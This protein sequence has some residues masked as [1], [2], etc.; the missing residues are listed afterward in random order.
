MSRITI[1]SKDAE[2]IART[3]SDLIG[4]KGLD[5]IRRKAVNKVGSDIRKQTRAIGP[6]IIGT[7]AAALMVQG[8]AGAPG[9][10]DPA[11]RLYMAS[12]IPVARMKA[13]KRKVTRRQGRAS[14]A[15]TLPGGDV[16]KFR[17]IHREGARFRLRKAGPLPARDLGGVYTN[18]R[19][20]FERYDE[21]KRVRRRGER[22]MPGIVAA[23]I[24]AHLEGR[25]T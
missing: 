9:A 10:S 21:L 15:L 23:L 7:T 5:R 4:P 6:A 25:R 12:K 24:E 20:A 8:K 3:F 11:Y 16:I 17:S 1:S 2:R 14:L 13:A 22:E 19:T 18:A